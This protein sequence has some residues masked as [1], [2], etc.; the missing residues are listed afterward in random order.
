[1][2]EKLRAR[3]EKVS[4]FL[5]GRCHHVVYMHVPVEEM[6]LTNIG[7]N[8]TWTRKQKANE[9]RIIQEQ[10]NKKNVVDTVSESS[11]KSF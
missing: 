10:Q 6:C 1:M 4:V 7:E 8:D 3:V 5:V 11:K 2:R 9:K